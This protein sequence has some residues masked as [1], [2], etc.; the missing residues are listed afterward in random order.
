MLADGSLVGAGEEAEA[1]GDFPVLD[2]VADISE[3]PDD[4]GDY[5]YAGRDL[6]DPINN[7]D[8]PPDG[9][10]LVGQESG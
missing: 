8:V 6:R 5:Q 10:A 2:G 4:E 9:N 3:K 1:V 7:L